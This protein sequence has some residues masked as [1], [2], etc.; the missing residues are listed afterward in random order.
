MGLRNIQ[1]ALQ[2]IV[3]AIAAVLKI[4]VEVADHELFRVA[5]T[6]L[7]KRKI[8]TNMYNE[9]T[10]Y[11]H[12]IETGKTIV[13]DQPGFNDICKSCS[14]FGNCEEKGEICFPIK[15]GNEVIGVIGL[16]AFDEEQKKRLF[17][18]QEENTLFLE[19]IADVIATKVKEYS[20]FQQ[21]LV[22]EQ[23]ISTLIH[24]MD[25]GVIMLNQYGQ[26]EFI[27]NT[28][29]EML[30]LTSHEKPSTNLIQQLVEQQ[31]N[32]ANEKNIVFVNV[33]S[34][35]R[36]LI[37]SYHQMNASEQGET[38]VIILEDPDYLKNVASQFT[39][40]QSLQSILIGTHPAMNKVV[41][42]NPK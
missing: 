7:L 37:A 34:F 16:I 24:Y 22:A 5:G 36:K 25:Q 39:I 23:K 19:K 27:N 6:G 28:A 17:A 21:Q 4:E 26:C 20:F 10:V 3:S 31:E 9:D 13:V 40:E 12:C 35:F 32:N 30:Q 42:V 1:S 11:R 18:Y 38:A 14:H 29:R 15:L 8:W 2:Q 33:G 41:N